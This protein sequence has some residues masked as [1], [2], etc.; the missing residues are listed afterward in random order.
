MIVA[1]IGARYLID[2]IWTGIGTPRVV[3]AGDLDPDGAV[4]L[5]D[6]LVSAVAL[7]TP[8]VQVE[9]SAVA[10]CHPDGAAALRWADS[11]ARNRN[12]R[13]RMTGA[14]DLVPPGA[15]SLSLDHRLPGPDPADDPLGEHRT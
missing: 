4:E 11:H 12:C 8:W 1:R 2:L 15:P 9:L 14:D 5:R 3:V 6:H 13:L 10:Y 7:G